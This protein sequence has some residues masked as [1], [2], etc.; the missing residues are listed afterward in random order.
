LRDV[1]GLE[2][3]TISADIPLLPAAVSNLLYARADGEILPI[4]KRAA[5]VGHNIA[6]DY[7]KT[8]GISLLA[9]RDFDEHDTPD[10]Q[11]VV[12]ISQGGAKKIFGN[13]DPLGKTLLIGS[14]SIPSQI[15]GIG[16]GRR[17][18]TTFSASMC[19]VV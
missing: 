5:A 7:F 3:A 4:D 16:H 19:G 1:P 10:R 14:A 18:T 15:V 17:T 8:W 9:G 12:I 11:N 13:E 6:P 2:S